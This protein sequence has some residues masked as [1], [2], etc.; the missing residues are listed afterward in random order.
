MLMPIRVWPTKCLPSHANRR[1]PIL[2]FLFVIVLIALAAECSLAQ[3]RLEPFAYEPSATATPALRFHPPARI[4]ARA[5]DELKSDESFNE[6]RRYLGDAVRRRDSSAIR[7][8]LSHDFVAVNC[9]EEALQGSEAVAQW[10]KS[11]KPHRPATMAISGE[12]SVLQSNSGSR[13]KL[14]Q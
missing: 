13:R 1:R 3:I 12:F 9:C 7:R 8:V 2:T 14:R 11:G 4:P 5:V 6:F 10:W